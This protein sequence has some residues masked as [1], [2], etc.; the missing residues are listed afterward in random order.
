MLT[1]ATAHWLSGAEGRAAVAA[2]AAADPDP[3][4]RTA[5]VRGLGLRPEEASAA[6]QQADLRDLAARRYGLAADDLLLT[7]D[8]LEQATRPD[9]AERRAQGLVASGARTVVDLT[10]GLGLDTRAFLAAGL[11]VIAVERDP[12]TAVLLAANGPGARVITGA[13]QDALPEVLPLLGE[14]DVVFVDPA[15]RDPAAP[16]GASLRARPERD[17]ERWSPP[18][19]WVRALPHGRIAVKAAP[20]LPPPPGWVAE[21]VGIG[22][23]VV[24]CY[25]RSWPA[26]PDRVAAVRVPRGWTEIAADHAPM[27]VGPLGSWLHEPD[28]AVVAAGAVDTAAAALGVERLAA[29]STWLTGPDPV[30]SGLVRSYPVLAPLVGPAR[31]QRRV[32]DRHGV[33][34][35]TVKSREARVAPTA[36][37]ADLARPEGS[38]H[39][40]VVARAQGRAVRILCGP[41]EPPAP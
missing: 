18:W 5:A 3:L 29:D 16:R 24:E 12:A 39:V 36:V 28:P 21:W 14:E 37:L 1:E 11:A 30:G 38:G 19:S 4:A 32:L 6:A 15:R 20:A 7:R 10:A 17:P 41:P 33:A 9:V 31:E 27:R 22:G 8:G 13:A 40:L 26:G 23:S 25:L 2:A 35:L 34:G